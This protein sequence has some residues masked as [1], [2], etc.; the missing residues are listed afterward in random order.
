MQDLARLGFKR[1]EI[2]H[3]EVG[4]VCKTEQILQRVRAATHPPTHRPRRAASAKP[5]HSH[6]EYCPSQKL[7]ELGTYEQEID[8]KRK[9]QKDSQARARR[10]TAVARARRRS[11]SP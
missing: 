7:A 9:L 3:I 5:L 1:D 2:D 6:H 4:R 10:C 8:A 11:L